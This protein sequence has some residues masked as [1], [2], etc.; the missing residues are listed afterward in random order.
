MACHCPRFT[1][2]AAEWERTYFGT[3]GVDPNADPDGD[4][5]SNQEEY[6]AGTNP[7]N[8]SDALI[9]KAFTS[10]SG[11]T[12]V[13]L[14]WSS[15]LTRYYFI[16]ETTDLESTLWI[17]SS[18]G[19]VVPSGPSTTRAFT[20]TDAP[21][22][23]YRVQ[24]TGVGQ[25]VGVSIG[26]TRNMIR[27]NHREG[28]A[29]TDPAAVCRINRATKLSGF[30][31]HFGSAV[32]FE[33]DPADIGAVGEAAEIA[34]AVIVDAV[35]DRGVVLVLDTIGGGVAPEMNPANIGGVEIAG[36]NELAN[37]GAAVGIPPTIY[38]ANV[39]AIGIFVCGIDAGRGQHL[40]ERGNQHQ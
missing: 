18:A 32:G 13:S 38:P 15:V 17:D 35:I 40:R 4:G 19:L 23:F 26:S 11:G 29:Q 9:I 8:S 27:L 28:V 10:D 39:R 2:Q 25:S 31:V 5:M 1:A 12:N 20:D 33:V 6:L 36:T 3:L 16:Q 7:T 22:R 30:E 21:M 34:Q 14:T 37:Y 24:A